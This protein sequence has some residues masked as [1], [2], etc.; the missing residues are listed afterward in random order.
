MTI[1]PSPLT[2]NYTFNS[3]FYSELR[4]FKYGLITLTVFRLKVL[5]HDIDCRKLYV[6][7]LLARALQ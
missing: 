4:S 5:N 1:N 3:P 6:L 2:L 7:L